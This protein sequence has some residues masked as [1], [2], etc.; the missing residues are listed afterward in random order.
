[1]KE[2]GKKK[3][4]IAENFIKEYFGTNKVIPSN[5]IM[6]EAAK[7]GALRETRF[8]RQKKKLGITS[9]KEKSRR[10]NNLLDMGNAGIKSLTIWMF[11][12][13]DSKF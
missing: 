3:L 5:E 1:M 13:A 12:K 4:D 9:D 7:K 8:Y 10:W 2:E 11:G 6:M